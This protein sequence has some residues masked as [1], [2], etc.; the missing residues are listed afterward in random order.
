MRRQQEVYRRVFI[1]WH[2]DLPHTCFFCQEVVTTWGRRSAE[3]TIHHIDEDFTNNDPGNLTAAH[4]GC[5]VRHHSGEQ[6][7]YERTPAIRAKT[8]AALRGKTQS[9]ESNAK[10]AASLRSAYAEGR[11]TPPPGRPKGIVTRTSPCPYCGREI[12][13]NNLPRHVAVHADGRTPRVR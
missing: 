1:A 10:R 11:K 6:V 9:P 5:H 4:M 7:P 3:G 2:G 8:S 12:A 13:T